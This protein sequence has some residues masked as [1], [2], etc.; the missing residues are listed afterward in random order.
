M[1]LTFGGK[2]IEFSHFSLKNA[3]LVVSESSDPGI[4]LS[5]F[6]G[7]YAAHELLQLTLASPRSSLGPFSRKSGIFE[8]DPKTP[9][10][11]LISD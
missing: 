6:L 11:V 10:F 2:L 4:A 5:P 7:H 8:T 1:C 3:K 9:V